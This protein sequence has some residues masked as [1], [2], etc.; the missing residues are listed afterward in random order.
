LPNR[1]WIATAFASG[2]GARVQAATNATPIAIIA[3]LAR[4]L[5]I[6]FVIEPTPSLHQAV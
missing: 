2:G 1:F 5:E 6:P 4:A 3:S